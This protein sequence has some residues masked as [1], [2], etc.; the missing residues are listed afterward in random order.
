M[1]PIILPPGN[2]TFLGQH[3]TLFDSGSFT[4]VTQGQIEIIHTEDEFL[5]AM[6]HKKNILHG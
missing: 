5:L 3:F 6:T 1:A 4:F 2:G